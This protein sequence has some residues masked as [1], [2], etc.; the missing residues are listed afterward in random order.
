MKLKIRWKIE[1]KNANMV[2]SVWSKTSQS[3]LKA[4]IGLCSTSGSRVSRTLLARRALAKPSTYR[5][6]DKLCVELFGFCALPLKDRFI[7]L[8]PIVAALEGEGFPGK[9]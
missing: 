8:F 1:K 3:V 7:E 5:C 6:R 4:Y 2:V 9:L